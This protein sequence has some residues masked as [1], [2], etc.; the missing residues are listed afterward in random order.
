MPT[1]ANIIFLDPVRQTKGKT[2]FQYY[3]DCCRI[4]FAIFWEQIPALALVLIGINN[5]LEY[6]WPENRKEWTN[7]I[8]IAITLL[9]AV[10]YLATEWLPLGAGN[11]NFS[12][13]LFVGIL[14]ALILGI[15]LLIVH[16]YVPILRWALKNKWKFMA[17]PLLPLAFGIMSWQGTNRIFGFMPE[18]IKN[19]AVWQSFGQHVPGLGKEFMPALDEGS[20]L[21]MPTSMPHSGIEMNQK[22]VEMLDK[23]L[24]T[25]PE[26]ELAVGKWGRINSCT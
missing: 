23:R 13:Y 22:Y 5:L 19:T 2:D 7:Y 10:W 26:V 21:L 14:I 18:F 11:S 15:L 16:F 17:M 20:F 6:K 3:S 9:V 24:S 25:I 4:L 12:N 8:N 1:L